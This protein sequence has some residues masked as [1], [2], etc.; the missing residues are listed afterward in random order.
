MFL[1]MKSYLVTLLK[2]TIFAPL[3][4]FASYTPSCKA[5]RSLIRAP[6]N[7]FSF[8]T[9]LVKRPTKCTILPPKDFLCDVIFTLW[10]IIFLITSLHLLPPHLSNFTY[11]LILHLL[12][13]MTPILP[14]P[15]LPTF[16]PHPRH[17]HHLLLLLQIL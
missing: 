3:V 1:R 2:T 6:T 7:L 10:N 8:G 14:L 17:Y 5:A 11:L 12:H 15:I 4:A 16:L 13:L 9:H